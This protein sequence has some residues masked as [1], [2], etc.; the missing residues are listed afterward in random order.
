MENPEDFNIEAETAEDAKT[1]HECPYCGKVL[2]SEK[3]LFS[4]MEKC[5][6]NP[7]NAKEPEPEV[8]MPQDCPK[9]GKTYKTKSGFDKHV[10]SCEGPK[11]KAERVPMTDEEKAA[12]RKEYVDRWVEKNVTIQ[13]RL[14]KG[15]EELDFV[16]ARVEELRAEDPTAG[17]ASYFRNLLTADMKK[18]AKRAAKSE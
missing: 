4:H 3:K 10:E 16:N 14:L 15:G 5:D 6:G 18:Y 8:W 12:K 9:C 13:I 2:K 17:W 7:K 1:E 11:V